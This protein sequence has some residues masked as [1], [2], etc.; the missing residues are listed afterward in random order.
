MNTRLNTRF[1]TQAAVIAAL[2]AAL[3]LTLSFMA[4]KDL[5]IRVAEALTI[6]PF[7]TPAAIPG[8]AIGCA[9]ANIFS[10]LGPIDIVVGG[11]ASFMAAFLSYKM[12]QKWLVP[13]PPI[14]LNGVIVGLELYLIADL[15]LLPSM[16]WVAL[17]EIIACFGLGYPLLLLLEKNGDRV[18]K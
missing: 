2:Y 3:T 4:Y 18:L 16:G 12:P 8:L 6:L 14:I 17:G 13:V 9:I 1:L 15:P 11:I 7:F 10:P 5:Q